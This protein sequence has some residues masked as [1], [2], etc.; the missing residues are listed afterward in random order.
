MR[1]ASGARP[2]AGRSD[3][4]FEELGVLSLKNIAHPV[5]AFVLKLNEDPFKPAPIERS[6]VA[7]TRRG[8]AATG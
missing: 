5:E 7:V 4:T 8:T 1:H 2:Y 6:P 3:L